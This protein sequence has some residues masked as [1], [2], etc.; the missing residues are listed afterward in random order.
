[1]FLGGTLPG[2]VAIGGALM[3]TSTGSSEPIYET[4]NGERRGGDVQVALIGLFADWYP[5]PK[6]GL[7]LMA[8]AGISG[9]MLSEDDSVPLRELR[10]SGVALAAGAG[11]D[12]F[13]GPDFSLGLLPLLQYQRSAFDSGRAASFS[14][15][16][17]ESMAVSAYFSMTYN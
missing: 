14:E 4:P 17:L 5:D 10:G 15:G 3:S 8:A 12:L 9:V 16:T 11:Y 1:L 13:V 6:G 7:H 2:G